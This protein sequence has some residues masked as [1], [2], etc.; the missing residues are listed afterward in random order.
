MSSQSKQ[1]NNPKMNQEKLKY[2]Y[3]PVPSWRLGSSLGIDL[4]S[5]EEK[6]C[7]FDCIYCQL[8]KVAIYT[9]K[10]KL[11]VSK[12]EIIRELKILP[13]IK[14]DYITFSGRGE[15]TLAENLGQVIKSV[16]A[17]RGE[18][19][20]VLTNSSLMDKEDVRN[21][22]SLADFVVA[23]L[24]AYSQKSFRKINKPAPQIE[25]SNVIAGIKKFKKDYSGKLALQI[26]FVEENKNKASEI[27]SLIND[28]HPDEI[29]INTP[30]R[31]CSVKPLSR[32]EIFKIKEYFFLRCESVFGKNKI[33]IV[34][35]YDTKAHKEV[36]PISD[37]DTLIRRGKRN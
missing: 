34:S 23:K 14:I 24:D 1:K 27:M 21:Q 8:A 32:E 30:L 7:S 37:K 36:I 22:L 35:V 26:M 29:Q 12:E 33:N 18:P 9:I 11:Y 16:R 4:L 5:Q 28:I 20:A 31:P 25:F 15:P 2:I 17:I 19:I 10:R 13:E 6:V 3:G